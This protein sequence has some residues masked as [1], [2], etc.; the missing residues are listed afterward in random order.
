MGLEP[1]SKILDFQRITA[2]MDL[3]RS[4]EMRE[5]S[6]NVYKIVRIRHANEEP[7]LIETTFIPVHIIPCLTREML[8]NKSLYEVISARTGNTPY[9]AEESYESIILDKEAANLLGCKQ[10]TSDFHIDRK[11]RMQD[12]TVFELTQPIMRGDRT[13]FVIKLKKQDD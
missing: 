5:D 4:L 2:Q 9:E 10:N 1:S 13:K 12:D 3:S 11:T 7:L 8:E 6:G